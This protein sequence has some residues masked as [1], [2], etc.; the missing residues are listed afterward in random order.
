M[1]EP[2][3]VGLLFADRI[4]QENNGKK[5]IIGTFSTFHSANFP[6]V[7]PPWGIYAA[8]TNLEGEHTF[9]INLVCET[10][11]QVIVNLSGDINSKS[12]TDVIEISPQIFN[13]VFPRAG[14]YDLTFS[15]DGH[16]IGSRRLTVVNDKPRE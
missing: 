4:I 13:A 7:F 12:S 11:N 8:V 15:I 5:G 16:T 1:T 2:V 6:V 9:A 3:F 10:S 14:K